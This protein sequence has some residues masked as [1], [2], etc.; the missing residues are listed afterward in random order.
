MRPEGDAARGVSVAAL[1]DVHG[2]FPALEAVLAETAMADLIVVGGDFVGGEQPAETIELL[3]SL[4]DRVRFIRG[5]A[6]RE[7]L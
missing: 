4:G 6:E 2:N 3:R 7:L 5:N 1:Y